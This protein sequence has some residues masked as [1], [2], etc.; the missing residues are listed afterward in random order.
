MSSLGLISAGVT[1]DA[2]LAS[3]LASFPSGGIEDSAT[4][5]NP[6]GRQCYAHLTNLALNPDKLSSHV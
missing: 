1:T 6:L 4:V 2:A 5:K 3:Y